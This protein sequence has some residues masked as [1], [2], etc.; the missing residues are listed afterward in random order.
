MINFGIQLL[1]YE[2]GIEKAYSW[3]IADDDKCT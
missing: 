1:S 3:C 2:Q